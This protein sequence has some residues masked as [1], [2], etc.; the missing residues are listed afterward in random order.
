MKDL[1]REIHQQKPAVRYALFVLSTF[2]VVSAI[3]LAWFTGFERDAYFALHADP[4][5]REAFVTRQDER[6]PQPLAAIGRGFGSLA[7]SIGSFIG[8]DREAG[9]EREPRHDPVHLLPLSR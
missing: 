8:L 5:D 4:A 9:F 3:G 1:I 7:A 2:V 6:L